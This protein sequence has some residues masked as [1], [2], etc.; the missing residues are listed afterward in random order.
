[1][2]TQIL[3]TL[4]ILSS[5][6]FCFHYIFSIYFFIL[7]YL[8]VIGSFARQCY[9]C[10]GCPKPFKGNEEGVSKITV[11]DNDYCQVCIHIYIQ[12][13]IFSSKC[14]SHKFVLFQKTIVLGVENRDSGGSDCTPVDQIKYCC[15]GD[16]CNGA[17][18]TTIA[19]KLLA[20]TT[21]LLFTVRFFQ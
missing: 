20:A 12:S 10:T 1:M 2:K 21:T 19:M 18:A 4:V 8:V 11:G 9:R 14:Y 13:I 3:I 5:P 7:F 6:H 15:K 17:T 16:L